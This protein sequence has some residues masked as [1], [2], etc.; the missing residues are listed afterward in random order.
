MGF[1]QRIT[2]YFIGVIREMLNFY[3]FLFIINETLPS[4]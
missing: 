1:L 4:S 3:Y 2:H